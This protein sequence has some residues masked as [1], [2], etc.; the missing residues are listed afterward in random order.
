METVAT[1]RI[2]LSSNFLYIFFPPVCPDQKA[3]VVFIVDSSGSIM[4]GVVPGSGQDNWRITK[5]FL[6]LVIEYFKIGRDDVRVGIVLFSENAYNVHYLDNWDE[7]R[8]MTDIDNLQYLDSITNT[9]G[10]IRTAMTQQFISR[11]GD[12]PNVPVRIIS[13]SLILNSALYVH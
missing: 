2:S 6:N 13:F 12:R 11:R 9:T 7:N 4:E 10:A 8:I 5:N 1:V 3:D